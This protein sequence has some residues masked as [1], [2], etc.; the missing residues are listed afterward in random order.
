MLPPSSWLKYD[1]ST[2]RMRSGY[3]SKVQRRWSL[4]SA[5]GREDWNPVRAE[6]TNEEEV[7]E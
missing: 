1:L 5:E 4:A 7:M 3:I 6:R 2:V